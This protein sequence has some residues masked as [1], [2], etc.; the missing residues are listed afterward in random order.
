M[1]VAIVPALQSACRPRI[2][3]KTAVLWLLGPAHG[4]RGQ[5]GGDAVQALCAS[6]E[7][8]CYGLEDGKDARPRG[9]TSIVNEH[10][11]EARS[12]AMHST[13]QP[14]A[15]NCSPTKIL[16]LKHLPQLHHSAL[17][18]SYSALEPC[19]AKGFG[20]EL[21]RSCAVNRNP[22][23]AAAAALAPATVP[24]TSPA[25]SP[26][27][28]TPTA[29]VTSPPAPAAPAVCTEIGLA[30]LP[31][32]SPPASTPRQSSP[33]RISTGRGSDNGG[34]RAD[35]CIRTHRGSNASPPCP[36]RPARPNAA[37]KDV[38]HSFSRSARPA[39]ASTVPSAPLLPPMRSSLPPAAPTISPLPSPSPNHSPVS[40]LSLPGPAFQSP[41]PAPLSPPPARLSPH[42]IPLAPLSPLPPPSGY[43]C[44]VCG[45]LFASGPALGGHMRRHLS[46]GFEAGG[47]AD[48][49]RWVDEP[50]GWDNHPYAG[51]ERARGEGRAGGRSSLGGRE[52]Q[53]V[54]VGCE[55]GGRVGEASG[56]NAVPR[57]NR[58][59][60]Q[61]RSAD[62]ERIAMMAQEISEAPRRAGVDGTGTVPRVMGSGSVRSF[63]LSRRP[64]L[65]LARGYSLT[66]AD[67]A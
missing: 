27:E 33:L 32:P 45:A 21:K 60:L 8:C 4:R 63:S 25:T 28:A 46:G 16:P 37:S 31:M 39:P 40:P 62:A 5:W 19:A 55:W 51:A 67:V 29:A 7:G 61:H 57:N 56:A 43:P 17:K 24:A 1:A 2:S 50:G 41:P 23:L 30:L 34:G 66:R 48:R 10:S 65:V 44:R 9:G 18:C 42:A 12:A 52:E 14:L 20:N 36:A 49:G 35:A 59:L 38:I 3:E 22:E 13:L 6:D 26:A 15:V 54:Q 58:L 64:S 47:K 53:Q 11:A